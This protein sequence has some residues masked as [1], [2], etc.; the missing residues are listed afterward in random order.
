MVDSFSTWNLVQDWIRRCTTTHRACERGAGWTAPT[1][2]IQISGSSTSLKARLVESAEITWDTHSKTDTK[3]GHS[4]P[5]YCTLS[6]CWGQIEMVKLLRCNNASFREHIPISTLTK[7]FREALQVAL[8]LGFRYIWIDSLC[9][10]QD[11]QEDWL[12]EASLMSSVYYFSALNLAA[13]AASD[14][15][16]GL[17]FPRYPPLVRACTIEQ[18]ALT[19]RKLDIINEA[20]WINHIDTSTLCQRAWVVQERFLARRTLH[21]AKNQLFWE[22]HE[23][24]ACETFPSKIMGSMS[25]HTA[26]KEADA[27]EEHWGD[28]VEL[29]TRASLSHAGDKLFALSGIASW[30]HERNGDEYIAGLW[31][32]GIERQLYWR[33]EDGSRPVIYRAPS[34]SWASVDG[35]IDFYYTNETVVIDVKDAKVQLESSDQVFGGV[36]SRFLT[37]ECWQLKKVVIGVDEFGNYTLRVRG[38]TGLTDIMHFHDVDDLLSQEDQI[39]LLLTIK[40]GMDAVSGLLLESANIGG[41]YRRR[42]H[43]DYYEK[44]G[45]FLDLE[46]LHSEEH[47]EAIGELDESGHRRYTITMI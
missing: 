18:P 2:L 19:N 44:H 1:R 42:G 33:V 14:G 31:R 23:I 3:V 13:T 21:F 45:L 17:F 12:R 29:Y 46:G 15:N 28:V 34:W 27:S 7:T 26:F 47:Y 5:G 36:K 38:M 20:L 22:C 10:M 8:R 11:S 35:E 16:E 40:R 32:T 30:F 43:F 41:Q 4:M 37:I 24:N 25:Y 39:Y 6:H 9:I